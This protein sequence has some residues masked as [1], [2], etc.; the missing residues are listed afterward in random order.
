MNDLYLIKIGEIKLKEGNRKYFLNKLKE[1]ILD[2]TRR[3]PETRVSIHDNRLFLKIPEG[4]ATLAET[5]LSSTPGINGWAKTHRTAID[6]SAVTEEALRL[7]AGFKPGTFKVEAR[8]SDKSYPMTSY[9]IAAGLGERILDAR[10]DLKVDVHNPDSILFVEIRDAAYLYTNPAKSV[11]GLPTGTAGKGLLLLSGGID[12]PIA[13][14]MM[15]LRGLALEAVHFAAY[16]YTSQ[17]AWD[18][19]KR[20]ALKLTPYTGTL[21]LHTLQFTE[22]QLAIKKN[23]APECATIYLR[24]AMVEAAHLLARETGCNSLVTGESLSQV[25]SQTAENIRF[26]QHT[27]DLPILR[28]LVGFDKEDTIKTA[29]AIGTFDISIEPFEDCCVLFSPK[30]PVLK[31]KFEEEKLTYKKLNLAPLIEEAVAKRETIRL[32]FDP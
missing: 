7:A 29:R 27:S 14:Y 3:V 28:P 11:R 23:S 5:V 12:S 2:K 21:T 30:H 26:T 32:E 15:A 9:E 8:R 31:A 13:G 18:K 25:A 16:P 22:L 10:P 20:L 19:V 4:H 24:A 1:N 17:E 6:F